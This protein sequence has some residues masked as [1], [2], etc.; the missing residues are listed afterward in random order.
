MKIEN[1]EIRNCILKVTIAVE[2]QEFDQARRRVYLDNTEHYP[3][4][5][6]A[7]GTAQLSDLEETYGPA[8]LY[9]EALSRVVPEMFNE[10]LAREGLRI[11]GR[12]RVDDMKFTGG[13]VSFDVTAELYPQV[14]LGRYLE[15]RVPYNRMGEQDLFEK[16]VLRQ[17][18]ENLQGEVPEHMVR[19]KLAAITAREK[20]NVSNEAIYHLLADANVI[21]NQAYEALGVARPASQVHHEAE[22]LMLQTVSGEHQEDWKEYFQEQIAATVAR[23]HDLP[24]DFAETLGRIIDRRMKNKNAMKQEDLIDE[25]FGYYLGSQDLSEKQWQEQRRVQAAR[26]VCLDLL[27]D[28][29]AEKEQIEL[30]PQELQDALEDIAARCNME[31]DDVAK[32]MDVKPLEWQLKRD[33]ARALILD[34]GVTDEEARAARLAAEEKAGQNLS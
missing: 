28:A 25:I 17:A 22:D 24:P 9:D 13:G 21:L 7:P 6:I 18:C 3:V 10:F 19:E 30:N 26:E 8:V 20:L 2:K 33:R 34:S 4:P 31:V 11:V 1:K 15:I 23:F 32:Q 14:E 29:V 5:G 16:A 27:L 12:P